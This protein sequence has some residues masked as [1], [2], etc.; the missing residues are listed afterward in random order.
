M[1]FKPYNHDALNQLDMRDIKL[2]TPTHIKAN[3]H[4][5]DYNNIEYQNPRRKTLRKARDAPVAS[6]SVEK[7]IIN[8]QY[9]FSYE[10]A[11][12]M[13]V[14]AQDI[15]EVKRLIEEAKVNNDWSELNQANKYGWTPL[16]MAVR[17]GNLDIVQLLVM[18]GQADI[19]AVSVAGGSVLFWSKACL[20]PTHLITQYLIS[21]HAQDIQIN[22]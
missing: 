19:N 18:E 13:A 17:T 8:N 14:S 1:H 4:Q 10:T 5:Q 2:T 20:S 9:A 22:E 11:M 12:H 7:D 6:A 15:D 3:N 21:L 16:H